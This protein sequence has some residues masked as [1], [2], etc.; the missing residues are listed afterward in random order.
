MLRSKPDKEVLYP[1]PKIKNPPMP[2]LRRT[3]KKGALDVIIVNPLSPTTKE[4]NMNKPFGVCLLPVL[5][6][7]A[8]SALGGEGGLSE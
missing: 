7:P 5:P 6:S 2:R 3:M 1:S 8:E 4:T